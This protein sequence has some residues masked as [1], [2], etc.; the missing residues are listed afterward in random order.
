MKKW[1]N[2]RDAFQRSERN[3]KSTL[4]SGNARQPLKTYIYGKQMLFLKKTFEGRPTNDSFFS[5]DVEF[6]S[7]QFSQSPG[8]VCDETRPNPQNY[9]NCETSEEETLFKKPDQHSKKKKETQHC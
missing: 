1:T 4:K 2:L 6:N 7:S 5:D 3:N 8:N 9:D